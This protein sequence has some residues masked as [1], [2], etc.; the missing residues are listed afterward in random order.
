MSKTIQIRESK[1]HPFR[2]PIEIRW[3]DAKRQS[4]SIL[5][6]TVDAS[7]YG[8]GILVPLQLPP[9]EELTIILKGVEV[10]RGAVMRHSQ[11]CPSG[12]KVGLYFRLT[13]LMQNIPDLD[14]LLE[15]SLSERPR[16][17]ASVLCSLL[18]RFTLRL[19]RGAVMKSKAPDSAGEL[20]V[21]AVTGSQIQPCRR[22]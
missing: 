17:I 8:L 3:M 7:I 13:L 20:R 14:E 1:R 16:G 2:A 12:F 4:H 18:L 19:W 15:G 5:G 11:P 6:T 22:S 21:D 9:D 10:C